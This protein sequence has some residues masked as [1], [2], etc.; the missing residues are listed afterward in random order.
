VLPAVAGE[1]LAD[2]VDAFCEGI[3]FDAEQ[4]DRVITAAAR[5]GLRVKLHADQFTDGGGAMLAAK[6]G[7]LSADH[8]E[9][10]G[11]DGI[12]ALAGAGTVAVL[13]PGAAYVLDDPTPPPVDALRRLRV[14]IA[15]ATDC[16][17]GTSPLLSLPLAM[18]LACTRFGLTVDE[19]LAGVTAHAARALG[20]DGDAGVVAPGT[21]ADLVV[22]DVET[23]AQLVYWLG[24]EP[25]HAVVHRGRVVRGGPS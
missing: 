3:A 7:A 18:H 13:L 4:V 23:P 15:V 9:H 25:V 21:R 24:A 12:A 6:H 1:G 20:L 14:P 8:L 11:S 22:W 10:A 5:L 17:P 16:N 19:A 2:A